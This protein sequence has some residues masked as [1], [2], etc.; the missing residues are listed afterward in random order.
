MTIVIVLLGVFLLAVGGWSVLS[1]LQCSQPVQGSLCQAV[2]ANTKAGKRYAP[3][4]AYEYG[5]QSYECACLQTFPAQVLRKRFAKSGSC[6]IY[7]N[8]KT[9]G[10][11]VLRRLPQAGHWLAVLLGAL[12]I[13][14]ALRG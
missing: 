7:V 12:L 3:V 14:S 9:P 8:P 4:F 2:A 11:F 5:G 6:T 1:T 13:L 10:R